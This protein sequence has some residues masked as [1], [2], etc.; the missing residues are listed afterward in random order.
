MKGYKQNVNLRKC[1]YCTHCVIA[2]DGKKSCNVTGRKLEDKLHKCP[3]IVK[4]CFY[5]DNYFNCSKAGS[6]TCA[7]YKIMEVTP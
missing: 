7:K 1:E 3:K 4:D 2:F 6:R 5:C